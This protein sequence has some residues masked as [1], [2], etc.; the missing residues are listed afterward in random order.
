MGRRSKQKGSEVEKVKPAC[1]YCLRSFDNE[2]VLYSHQKLTHFKCPDCGKRF[3]S[4]PNMNIH[5]K[6]IHGYEL[7]SVPKAEAGRDDPTIGIMGSRGVP[8]EEEREESM[9]KR[10]RM[11]PVSLDSLVDSVAA[12]V[13]SSSSQNALTPAAAPPGKGLVYSDELVSP[14]EKRAALPRYRFDAAA[15]KEKL[16]SKETSLEAR[17]VALRN[18]LQNARQQVQGGTS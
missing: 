5:M 10:A 7:T 11:A 2:D 6:T 8:T 17:L 1:F 9:R 16:E 15:M 18:R 4:A 12:S 13:V 3:G 14:E